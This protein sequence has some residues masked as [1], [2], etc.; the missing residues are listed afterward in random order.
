VGAGV[1]LYDRR[2]ARDGRR[3]TGGGLGQSREG[4]S[5]SEREGVEGACG[6]SRRQGSIRGGE[7]FPEARE[8][9]I[10]ATSCRGRLRACVGGFS[11]ACT[12]LDRWPPGEWAG[13]RL[14]SWRGAGRVQGGGLRARLRWA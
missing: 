4:D 7:R 11:R 9:E 5:G 14:G 13:A 12:S 6:F 10:E 1:G 8:R 2:R 3:A